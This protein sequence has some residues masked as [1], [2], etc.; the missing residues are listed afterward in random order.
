[1]NLIDVV[2]KF[3][4]MSPQSTAFVEV[5]PLSGLRQEISSGGVPQQN[6]QD[7][8]QPSPSRRSKTGQG[9]SPRQEFDPVAGGVLC[10]LEDGRLGGP[11]Q[12]PIHQRGHSL[13]RRCGGALS[14]YIR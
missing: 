14:L 10:G 1:M 12:L 4:R 3:A 9:F 7:C 6:Q 2:A 8:K 13:L 11:P 5:R